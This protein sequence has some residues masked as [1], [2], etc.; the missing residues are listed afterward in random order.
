MAVSAAG[1]AS[2]PVGRSKNPGDLPEGLEP[3][4]VLGGDRRQAGQSLFQ[5]G[6]DLDALDRVDPEIALDVHV[7]GQHLGRVARELAHHRAQRGLDL[8]P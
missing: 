1:A 4:H 6:E 7:E 8:R 2:A 3:A 5:G